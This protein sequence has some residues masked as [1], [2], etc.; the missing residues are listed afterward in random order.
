M[1][2]AAK[3][4]LPILLLVA[5]IWGARAT[6]SRP[7]ES[8]STVT[9]FDSDPKHIWNRL[10][11][12]VFIRK[13]ATGA[14]HG[15]EELDP[16]FWSETH[17]LLIGSSHQRAL[18]V[19][20]EFLRTSAENQV[21]DPSKRAWLQ[22]NLWAVFDWSAHRWDN[23]TAERRELQIRLAEVLRRIAMKAEEIKSL[24][25]NYAQAV[26]SGA[27]AKE[28]DPANPD[29]TFLPPDLLQ[30]TGP[31]VC[32]RGDQGPVAEQHVGEFSGRSRFLVFVRLPQGRKATLDYFQ[33][34]WSAPDPWAAGQRDH[35]NGMLDPSLP[36][37]PVGTQAALVRQMLLFDNRGTLVATPITESV[38]IRVYRAIPPRID[39][40]NTAT[41]W[42]AA[43]TEQDFH[44]ARL[45]PQMLFERK[46]GGLRAVE[47][48]EREFSVFATQGWDVFEA[49]ASRQIRQDLLQLEPQVLHRCA[50]CHS[51]PGINSLQ[52]RRKLLKPN[53][54]QRAPELGINPDDAVYGPVWWEAENT[55]VW[56]QNRY[57]W[58]LLNG[59]W[60]ASKALR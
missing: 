53:R 12:A 40:N 17:H 4:L 44:E 2:L 14:S 48:G 10:Y 26:A 35:Q 45:N 49:S 34:L 37:F 39:R 33:A 28:Y 21:S 20:D 8:G 54:P 22:H 38:Q 15:L 29:R 27:F 32:I 60:K 43:R 41:D 19:L 50:G 24:P 31:W 59:Y 23:H 46:D 5:L 57:D 58:G 6:L 36:Q 1:R 16:L 11:D 47:R 56:K 52:S 25:D 30:P 55:L 42:E 18:A 51:A 9:I 7:E 13:D 3:A